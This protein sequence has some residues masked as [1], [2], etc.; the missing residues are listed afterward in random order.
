MRKNIFSYLKEKIKLKIYYFQ[1][2][3]FILLTKNICKSNK[4]ESIVSQD[5]SKN[6]VDYSYSCF[7]IF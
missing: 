3:I 7:V 5:V 2:Y 1:K 6:I 4:S